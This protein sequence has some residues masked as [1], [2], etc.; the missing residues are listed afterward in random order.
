MASFGQPVTP[1]TELMSFM[2]SLFQMI[3]FSAAA[4][5]ALALVVIVWLCFKETKKP[6][7]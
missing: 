4:L 6:E 7:N 5:F 1:N 2:G 3:T